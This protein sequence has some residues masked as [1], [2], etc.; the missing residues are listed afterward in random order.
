VT[1]YQEGEEFPRYERHK[2]ELSAPA[3]LLL[4]ANA[5]ARDAEYYE[6]AGYEVSPMIVICWWRR[7]GSPVASTG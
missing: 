4:D 6:L 5:R 1:R 3:Q 7:I 2:G